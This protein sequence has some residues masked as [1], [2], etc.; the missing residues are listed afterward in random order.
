MKASINNIEKGDILF[1]KSTAGFEVSKMVDGVLVR[2]TKM[3][4]D[5]YDREYQIEAVGNCGRLW[6]KDL[7]IHNNFLGCC[8]FRL[9]T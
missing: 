9:L 5:F 1:R 7:K 3:N 8:R 4:G 6:L 2:G